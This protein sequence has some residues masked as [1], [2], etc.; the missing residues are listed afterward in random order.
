MSRGRTREHPAE[1]FGTG[2]GGSA[3]A[4]G[5][6]GRRAVNGVLWMTAQKWFA[7]IGGLITVAILAR[8]LTPE[9]FGVVAVA[10]TILPLL[11]LL[12][13][14]GFSTYLVQAER[15]D[16]TVSSTSFWFSSVAGVVLAGALYF[17]AAPLAAIFSVPEATPVIQALTVVVV[18]TAL[19]ATP[20]ALLR[21]RLQFG[22]LAAQSAVAGVVGQVAAIVVAI[23]GGGVWAL[24]VQ[25]IVTQLVATILVFF[26]VDWHPHFAFSW[27]Q[28]RQMSVFGIKVVSVDAVALA[29]LWAENAII[30]GVLGVAALGYLS[31]A[32]KVVQI[33]QDLSGSAIAPVSTVVF[34]Q[35]R[36][37]GE[38]LRQGYLRALELAYAATLP[39][40]VLLAVAAPLIVPL[41][42]G[43]QWE[44][45]VSLTQALAV[46]ALFT[47]GAVL[48]HGLFYG[49]GKPGRWLVYA[50]VVDAATVLMTWAVVG[51]GLVAVGLGFVVIAFAAT[52]ARW[53]L[54]GGLVR[55]A[56]FRLAGVTARALAVALA[57]ALPG[58]AVMAVSGALPA[59]L[60]LVLVGV[61]VG[62]AYLLA[63]RIGMRG[64]FGDIRE[65]L[66]TASH[67]VL[68]RVRP[69]ARTGAAQ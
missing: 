32:Q 3:D 65:Y 34:A 53:F 42:F 47:L 14:L 5:L 33:S 37:S 39:P 10:M 25:A 20:A 56:P 69:A 13:D 27:P 2:E 16:A 41:F 1:Q 38:R 26:A 68:A 60:R 22:R 54:V 36:G 45:S 43:G 4:D 35:L 15:V 30:A 63:V 50:I 64:A 7:R 9:D 62:G 12:A 49:A 23:A 40:L 55:V 46:A 17:A 19:A 29:R 66:R 57:A 31:I 61:V 52:A 21:R 11:Y 8:L 51:Y 67:R 48:D 44:A 58:L 24:V 28:F 6:L 18:L 59:L